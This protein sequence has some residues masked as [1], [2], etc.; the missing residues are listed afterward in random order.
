MKL[1]HIIPETRIREALLKAEKLTEE[2]LAK[3]KET[4]SLP[5]AINWARLRC[6]DASF[7]I[8][9]YS[10]PCILVEIANADPH[11]PELRKYVYEW[12]KSSGIEYNVEVQ[13][14]W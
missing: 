9:L 10:D 13:T 8:S 1:R 11:C 12:L 7:C 3:L 4:E 2:A 5:E 6:A 14:E